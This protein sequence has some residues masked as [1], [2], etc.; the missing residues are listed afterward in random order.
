[1]PLHEPGLA[2]Q[3]RRQVASRIA[4][5]SD[6]IVADTVATFPLSTE[7]RRLDANYC[8]RLGN[9]VT[10]LMRDAILEARIDSRGPGISE[11]STT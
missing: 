8:M 2:V 1:M 10:R 3:I 6:V 7:S 11:L 9:L 4:D 5:R